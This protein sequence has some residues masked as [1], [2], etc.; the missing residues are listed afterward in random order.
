M[1][2]RRSRL[3]PDSRRISVRSSAGPRVRAAVQGDRD[4]HCDRLPGRARARRDGDR[5]EYRHQRLDRGGHQRPGRLYP[6][7]TRPRPLQ[8][9]GRALGLQDVHPRRRHA[10]HRGNGHRQ[11]AVV[12]RRP[13]REGHRQRRHQQHRVQRDDDLADD[14][15]QAHLGA[16]A[17]RPPGLHAAAADARHA[18]HADDIRR[19]R[20]LGHARVGRQRIAHHPRQPD[21]QQRVPD[22]RGAELRHRRRHRVTGTTRR[23]WTRSRNSR[24]RPR[25][26]TPR[27]AAPAAASST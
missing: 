11:H 16:A 9:H 5:A 12:G 7:A 17:E 14:R 27:S 4:G 13:R 23:R 20:F 1:S 8:N 21:R 25:A 22:R 6:A 26:W 10:A 2:R 19:D 24:C 18:L 3:V 15:E